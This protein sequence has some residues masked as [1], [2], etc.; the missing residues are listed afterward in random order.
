VWCGVC[1]PPPTRERLLADMVLRWY[2]S[3]I[4]SCG[5][6]PNWPPQRIPPI[7]AQTRETR[8]GWPPLLTVETEVN[9][10]SRSTNE[11]GPSLVGLL[12]SLC[13]YK[14]FCPALVDICFSS[15]YTFS[16][17]LSP[18]SSKL[19]QAVV[20]GHLSHNVC[21]SNLQA[22]GANPKCLCSKVRA[23]L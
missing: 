16:V 1:T 13:W 22:M 19:G 12:G 20:V 15:P 5:M 23:L 7:K 11:R 17:H 14:R 3:L 6:Q 9:G 10:D 8:E 4:I 2:A 18:S 21:L